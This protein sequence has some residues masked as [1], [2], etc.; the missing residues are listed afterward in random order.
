MEGVVLKKCTVKAMRDVASLG[1]V[2]CH[3][4]AIAALDM[5]DLMQERL[6][7]TSRIIQVENQ[8]IH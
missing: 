8:F 1:G 6:E 2:P 5:C 4:I 3:Q 7:A